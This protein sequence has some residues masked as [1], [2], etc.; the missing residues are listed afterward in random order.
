M[1]RNSRPDHAG[2]AAQVERNTQHRVVRARFVSRRW[3]APRAIKIGCDTPEVVKAR[4]PIHLTG[5]IIALLWLGMPRHAQRDQ[6]RVQP[7]ERLA[8]VV[9]A[10]GIVRPE[11]SE[12]AYGQCQSHGKMPSS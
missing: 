1:R 7:L 4:V 9:R 3:E 10:F 5:P 12:D 8:K 11:I 6:V 2:T